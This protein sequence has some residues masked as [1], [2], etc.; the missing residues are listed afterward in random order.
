MKAK[1]STG[2][3]VI[4]GAFA[5]ADDAAAQTLD[6]LR[7][8]RIVH[9]AVTGLPIHPFDAPEKA[10]E[11]VEHLGVIYLQIGKYFGFE[12]LF[13]WEHYDRVLASVSE[14]LQD[15]VR[16][17]RLAP[18]VHSIRFSGAD[19]FFVLYNL[20]VAG[21]GRVPTNLE[22]EAA[23]LRASV[24]RRLR[25]SIEGTTA[26]FINILASSLPRRTTP[27]CGPRATSSERSRKPSR[28][29]A[30]GRRTRSSSSSPG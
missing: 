26:D 5:L 28:S 19:G 22:G 12:E 7:R 16:A 8:D 14:S 4:A 20:P 13:G 24:A 6:E 9:D 18:L 21:R 27:E 29:S 15:D 11:R 3:N 2:P 23:R 25:Q 1:R 30:R 17:S 10:D